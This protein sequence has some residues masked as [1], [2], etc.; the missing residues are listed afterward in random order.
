MSGSERTHLRWIVQG[1]ATPRILDLWSIR[2]RYGHTVAHE[3]NPFFENAR[4]NASFIIKHTVRPHERSILLTERPVVTKLIV[5]VGRD[6]L[7]MGGHSFFIEERAFE[8]R[9]RDFLGV[10]K[11]NIHYENDYERLKELA[12]MPSFDPFLMADTFTR[13]ERPVA[14]LYFSITPKEQAEMR[15]YVAR[16]ISGFVGMAFGAAELAEDDD[17]ALRFAEQLLDQDQADKMIHLRKTLGMSEEEY[18]EGIFGWK[19]MLYYRW[20]LQLELDALKKFAMELNDCIVRGATPAEHNEINATR[21]KI[22]NETRARW[23][24]LTAVISEYDTEFAKFCQGG[25]ASSIR[26]FL[27]KAPTFF[28]KLG[29]DL[30]AVS[31]VTS[32]WGYW[33]R[34]REKG[35]LPARDAM[36]IFPAFLRSL[37]REEGD[38]EH[39]TLSER[40]KLDQTQ[41][42]AP[43]AA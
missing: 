7:G 4:L 34:E 1:G 30:S 33:W 6:D 22:L 9:L 10:S 17:R 40:Q 12:K 26:S 29:S 39:E 16:Q 37:I 35:S 8:R 2:K 24:G 14:R 25:D 38:E 28:F 31:H 42:Q 15:G 19:G 41:H 27:L 5:P 32:F 23:S 43:P 21:R 13:C 18:A 3:S 11:H 36:E 20:R